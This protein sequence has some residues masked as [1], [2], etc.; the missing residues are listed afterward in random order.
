[1]Q[2]QGQALSDVQKRGVAE[3]MS[4]RP[5]GS[6]RQGDAANMP[7]RC[8]SQSAAAGSGSWRGLERMGRRPV[9]Y[10]IPAGERRRADRRAGAALEAEM[11]VRLSHRRVCQ[12]TADDRGG[13]RLCRQRQRVR[14]LA[15]RQDRLRLLVVRERIDRAQRA[16]DRPGD[17][18]GRG[19]L[20]RLLR[21]RQGQ[22]LRAR[23]PDRPA[24]VEDES[25]SA[26]HRAHH[27]RHQ[28][29]RR[30]ALRPGL[31][32]RGIQQRQSRLSVLLV[33]RQRRGARREHRQGDLESLGRARGAASRTRRWPTA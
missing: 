32:V 27:R 4:G 5:L 22:R 21:R 3:F 18:P 6:A 24:A 26:L 29:V 25:R 17:R 15:R 12:R 8:A 31:L 30:Q 19:A 11:G 16:D 20:R 14:L 33:A 1:M 28:A 2:A 10:P 13:T 7:N 9:E 23:R